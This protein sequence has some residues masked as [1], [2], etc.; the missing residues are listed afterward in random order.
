MI[1]IPSAK[2]MESRGCIGQAVLSSRWHLPLPIFDW[3]I[4]SVSSG[5]H[6]AVS[7]AKTEAHEPFVDGRN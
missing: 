5:R 7:R 2:I 6:S 3:N 4:W 1:V